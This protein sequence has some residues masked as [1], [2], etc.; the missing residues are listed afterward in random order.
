MSMD[1]ALVVNGH[2]LANGV[3]QPA[4]R[5]RAR[6][7]TR[8]ARIAVLIPCHNEELTIGAVVRDFRTQLPAADIYVYDNNSSDRTMA[9]AQE[10]GAICRRE[11]KQGKGNVVRRMFA[12]IE[13]DVYIMVDGDDTYDAESV[14]RLIEP[15]LHSQVDIVNCIRK[16]TVRNAFRPGHTF[17][18]TLLTMIV[19]RTFG[20]RFTDMLSGY[21]AMSRRFVKSFPAMSEGFEI[22]T[23]IAVH[24]LELGLPI[25]EVAAPYKQRP[26]G[27]F[28]KLNTLRDG[29]RILLVILLLL[30]AER[31]FQFFASVSAIA[32]VLIA[33][34]TPPLF[35]TYL[36]TG[37]VPRLPTA[38]LVTGL[39]I[40]ALLTLMSG[41]ILETVTRGRREA[42]RMHYLSI[43]VLGRS[44]TNQ[45]TKASAGY[46]SI[47]DPSS[48][49][50]AS[51]NGNGAR[52]IAAKPRLA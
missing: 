14:N 10:A 39:S 29:I 26:A 42:K 12:D 2:A 22:E 44:A 49:A 9:V 48:Q 18:N 1:G 5:T 15:I 34:L 51:S 47:G 7:Q 4:P 30:K 35:V 31:P 33:I 52:K 28:S 50:S 32:F 43:P 38:V 25:V 13:A 11:D 40:F 36:E 37:L 8:Q 20:R 3:A 24:A 21:R 17:G 27:S 46:P 45:R 41:M 6:V 23:E 19:S 16:A